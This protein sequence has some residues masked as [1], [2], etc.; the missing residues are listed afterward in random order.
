MAMKTASQDL[1]LLV[2]GLVTKDFK[3]Y[4]LKDDELI[5]GNF[6]DLNESY[7]TRL[8]FIVENTTC[9]EEVLAVKKEEQ[10]KAA[11][12]LKRIAEDKK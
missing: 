11:I 7:I 6:G 12:E 4:V 1:P 5:V 9:T 2:M 8:G 3:E 10:R